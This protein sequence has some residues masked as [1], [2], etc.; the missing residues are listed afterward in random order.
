MTDDEDEEVAVATEVK[1]NFGLRLAVRSVTLWLPPWPVVR[2]PPRRAVAPVVAMDAVRRARDV[3]DASSMSGEAED[4][5]ADDN[6]EV[7]ENDAGL[8][9]DCVWAE[10]WLGSLF[11]RAPC[12]LPLPARPTGLALG[13][14]TRDERVAAA[15]AEDDAVVDGTRVDPV[16][17]GGMTAMSLAVR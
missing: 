15:A 12:A 9:L 6:E 8:S 3:P 7:D 16:T 4:D 5:A 13:L 1:G 14:D 17:R 2:R 11:L 10:P